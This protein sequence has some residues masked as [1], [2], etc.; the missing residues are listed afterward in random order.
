M[1]KKSASVMGQPCNSSPTGAL[2]LTG[3]LLDW[4]LKDNPKNHVTFKGKSPS[5]GTLRLIVYFSYT[6]TQSRHFQICK[7]IQ[8]NKIAYTNCTKLNLV[9]IL[10]ALLSIL[11]WKQSFTELLINLTECNCINTFQQVVILW[12][13]VEM[14]DSD[15]THCCCIMAAYRG[16]FKWQPHY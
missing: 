16:Q 8:E 14:C 12:T 4:V 10:I 11:F 9:P 5:P 3:N 6:M 15:K 13:P 2:M 1:V 7:C